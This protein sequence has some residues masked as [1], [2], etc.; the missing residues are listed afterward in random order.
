MLQHT[1]RATRIVI[2][3]VLIVL[4]ALLS[5]PLVPGPGLL[6]VFGGLTVLSSEFE[7]A[8]RWKNYLH[9]QFRRLTGRSHGR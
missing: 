6:L 3:I 9:E 8:R 4:G 1:V 5:L 2:G 7:W